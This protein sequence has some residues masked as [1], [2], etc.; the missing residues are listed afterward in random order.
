M[1]RKK[2]FDIVAAMQMAELADEELSFKKPL[3]RN[4]VS[5]KFRDFWIQWT[6]ANGYKHYGYLCL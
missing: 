2:Q 5:R 6:D 1:K 4:E 3:E